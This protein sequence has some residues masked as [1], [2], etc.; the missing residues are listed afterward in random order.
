MTQP[1]TKN[2]EK[3]VISANASMMN[4]RPLTT[5]ALMAIMAS[6]IGGMTFGLDVDSTNWASGD[7]FRKALGWPVLA[8]GQGDPSWV[9]R[10]NGLILASFHLAAMISAPFAGVFADRFG[11]KTAII[12]GCILFIVGALMQA[13][14]GLISPANTTALIIVGRVIGGFGNGFE[15]SI[16]PVYG[17]E[18]APPKWRGW[19]VTLFQLFITIG[20]FLSNTINYFCL[21]HLPY[22]WRIN[23]SLQ[24]MTAFVLLVF[25]FFMPE[26]PR[27][28]ANKDRLSEAKDVLNRLAG[29]SGDDREDDVEIVKAVQIELNEIEDEVENIRKNKLTVCQMLQGTVLTALMVGVPTGAIQQITGVNWFMSY[30]PNVLNLAGF[31]NPF[32]YNYLQKIINMVSTFATFF[33]VDRI[34]RKQLLVWG[35]NVIIVVFTIFTIIFYVA[36]GDIQ[37]LP[38]LP[39]VFVI[40]VYFFTAAYAITWGP[41]GWLIL[42]EVMPIHI[43]GFGAGLGTAANMAFN[44]YADYVPN[45]VMQPEVWGLQG[46]SLSFL[47]IN[48]VFTVP[49]VYFLLPE[50]GKVSMEEMR[51]VMNYAFGGSAND[52]KSNAGTFGAFVRRNWQQTKRCFVCR[53]VDATLGVI[54]PLFAQSASTNVVMEKDEL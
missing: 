1:V 13:T 43:R 23:W 51:G 39:I 8:P 45:T 27:Y 49:Y 44:V 48:L 26:S 4:Q 7:N 14:A 10:D 54:V 11:R 6:C 35:T 2:P 40:A 41:M 42:A 16:V 25:T 32:L 19:T 38:G 15:C 20:I 34:G 53:P 46:T 33:L 52:P 29:L 36:G 12:V 31:D 28:F 9:T 17:A 47:L 22:G 21:R 50:T 37:G 5:Y 24:A 18:L 3:G 30:L